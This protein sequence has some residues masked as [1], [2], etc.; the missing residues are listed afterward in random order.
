MKTTWWMV[1][2]AVM[3]LAACGGAT[4]D[5]TTT[6]E[7]CTEGQTR[8]DQ[9][10]LQQCASG[11]WVDWTDCAAAGQ[12]CALSKGV[13]A[14]GGASVGTGTGG[15]D[16]GTESDAGSGTEGSID[17]GITDNPATGIDLGSSSTVSESGDT[18]TEAAGSDTGTSAC[19]E[20]PM[21][22]TF[23]P[24]RVMFLTDLSESMGDAYGIGLTKWEATRDTIVKVMNDPTNAAVQ[25]G[26]DGIPVN[27]Q[28]AGGTCKVGSSV[29]QDAAPGTPATINLRTLGLKP[30]GSVPL[31]KALL[32][33]DP[34]L[35]PDY[36][37]M[38]MAEGAQRY[39][40]VISD[41]VDSCGD[42]NNPSLCGVTSAEGTASTTSAAMWGDRTATLLK[43]GVHTITVGLTEA[44]PLETQLS[45]IA[46]AGG[47]PYKTA[48]ILHG[49]STIQNSLGSL[50]WGTKG[51]VYTLTM[52]EAPADPNKVNLKVD[53]KQINRDN[54]CLHDGWHW[55]EKSDAIWQVEMC[56]DLCGRIRESKKYVV[57]AT[58]GCPT[59]TYAQSVS[60]TL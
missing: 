45:A 53:G 43:H 2:G 52:P 28:T 22:I 59:T 38:F 9:A 20:V 29:F 19:A 16:A 47:M 25:F 14:C 27:T 8:C 3:G 21:G 41:V 34:D 7:G 57:K 26:F 49:Q 1:F 18:G 50:I 10:M 60:G 23:I 4:P 31:C 15:A 40:V 48:N 36:A 51:C 46:A 30:S 6:D 5:V 58:Y 32:N 56:G 17:T 44:A 11:A 42:A 35:H 24:T 55:V 13:A 37:P 12:G 33:Y 39:L 54:A